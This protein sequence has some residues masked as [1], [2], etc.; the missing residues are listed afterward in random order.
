M[1][2][3]LTH[4][5][6]NVGILAEVLSKAVKQVWPT[7]CCIHVDNGQVAKLPD[8]D[9][10]LVVVKLMHDFLQPAGSVCRQDNCTYCVSKMRKDSKQGGRLLPALTVCLS[11]PT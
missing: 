7:L 1:F 11:R 5:P 4:T 9:D 6:R 3:T 8:A 10:L 2:K